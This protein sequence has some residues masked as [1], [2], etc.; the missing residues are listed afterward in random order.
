M[1]TLCTKLFLLLFVSVS[2][3]FPT[4]AQNA[5]HPIK[6]GFGT[7]FIDY[8]AEAESY[9]KDIVDTG[10][11]ETGLVISR[12]TISTVLN[13]SFTIGAAVSLNSIKQNA[14][15]GTEGSQ[16]FADIELNLNYQF[17]NGALLN[18]NALFTPYVFGAVGTNYLENNDVD[19]TKFF[20]EGKLGIGT[21]IWVTP[22][23]GFNVQTAYVRQFSEQGSDYGHH[24]V[25]MVIRFGKGEDNDNDGIANWEDNCADVAGILAFQGCPDTDGDN[26]TDA[27]DACPTEPGIELFEGCPDTDNDGLADRDDVCPY[28]KGL[29][30]YKGCPDKDGDGVVD[31]DDRCIDDKGEAIFSGC[32][33]ADGDAIVDI[34][35][36]C[37]DQKGLLRFDGCPDTD[38]D[39]IQDA[40]DGC[41]KERGEAAL[42]GC[43]DNDGDGI[44]N[45]ADRCP[46]KPGLKVNGGCPVIDEEEK[47]QIIEKINYAAKSIQF[48]SGSDV[49]KKSS[50]GTLDNIVTIMAL[51]K[52]TA[53][54][55]EGHTDNEGDDAMNQTLSDKRAAAVKKY[56]ISKG[57]PEERL[58]SIGYG[59][60]VPI[61]DNKTSKGRAENRRVEIK[62]T[63]E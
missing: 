22:M 53:W 7:N 39:G 47:K 38:G 27:N 37:P 5:D 24:S 29:M 30:E 12:Y 34:D 21:D 4:L 32:P 61:A 8:N 13:K 55:I 42:K 59:E 9:I 45:A 46:D 36:F 19:A 3:L 18:T 50:Y 52:T 48:E 33:D 25:G 54:S 58:A 28:D 10:D 51:Y 20:P 60:T 2:A 57:I 63:A 6:F 40:E 23:F 44:A 15:T 35:D 1:Q 26:I 16:L 43:P 56:F 31:K 17:A 41:P 62:L 11:I 14:R 49:I